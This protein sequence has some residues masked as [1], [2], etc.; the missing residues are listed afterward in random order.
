M[1]PQNHI[2]ASFH[3]KVKRSGNLHL[4]YW[5]VLLNLILNHKHQK[6]LSKIQ[7]PW[8]ERLPVEP[9]DSALENCSPFKKPNY[10]CRGTHLIKF[11]HFTFY[12]KLLDDNINMS[13]LIEEMSWFCRFLFVVFTMSRE[14]LLTKFS[15]VDAPPSKNSPKK[16]EEVSDKKP[17]P[18]DRLPA[19][20]LVTN[21]LNDSHSGF[22]SCRWNFRKEQIYSLESDIYTWAW[23]QNNFPRAG[24][25]AIVG[26]NFKRQ[27]WSC[28]F[29]TGKLSTTSHRCNWEK[30]IVVTEF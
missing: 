16:Q 26:T 29:Y 14:P 21:S 19:V 6:C 12:T 24:E 8:V 30:G 22:K 20:C 27:H 28:K 17:F 25:V 7:R 4:K 3:V 15:C 1:S 11:G 5:R 18:R 23:G 2:T 9:T 13:A 10:Y